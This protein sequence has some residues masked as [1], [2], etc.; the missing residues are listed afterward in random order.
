MVSME[1][2]FHYFHANGSGF[3]YFSFMRFYHTNK[4]NIQNMVLKLQMQ[5]HWEKNLTPKP[6]GHAKLLY[7]FLILCE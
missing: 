5:T 7:V 6:Y 2:T 1:M 3:I 4:A